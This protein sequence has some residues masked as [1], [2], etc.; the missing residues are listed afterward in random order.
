M[1]SRLAKVG[2]LIGVAGVGLYTFN[3]IPTAYAASGEPE[4][5]FSRFGFTSLR[6]RAV[7]TVNQNTKRLVFEFPNPE[8]RSGLPLT[9][10]RT[11]WRIFE[12]S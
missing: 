9:C 12:E 2:G 5:V 10:M 7:H 1:I 11:L 4:M 3:S 8:A 6:V